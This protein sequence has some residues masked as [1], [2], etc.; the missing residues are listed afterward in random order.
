MQKV[1][2]LHGEKKGVG[3]IL[4]DKK[5]KLMLLIILLDTGQQI[6]LFLNMLEKH[7]YSQNFMIM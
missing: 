3:S 4:E 5:T 1:G 6:L 2:M 7:I